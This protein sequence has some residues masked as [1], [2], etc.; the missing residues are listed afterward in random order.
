MTLAERADLTALLNEHLS[1]A[2]GKGPGANAAAKVTSIVAG[3]AAGADCIDDLDLLRHGA[4]EDAFTGI[5]APSTLGTHLRA[6]T[7]G[8]IR[9]LDAVN[10]RFLLRLHRA[11]GL[12]RP[13]A[14][15]AAVTYIDIDDTMRQMHGYAQQGVAYG[16][17]CQRR[18]QID[19]LP[20]QS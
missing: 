1:V 4:T 3:M 18:S 13:L 10:S 6:Y 8:H 15:C 5:R 9:Q 20:G 11:S 17:N 2:A 7:F 16:Y 14:S 19:P 12:L